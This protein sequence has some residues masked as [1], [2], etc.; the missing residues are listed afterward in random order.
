[1]DITSHEIRNPLSAILQS[2]DGIA[3][4]MQELRAS[5]TQHMSEDL[6][7]STTEAA[8]TIVMCA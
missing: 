1:M 6:L 3:T 5:D 4:S 2:A 7:E 8:Q